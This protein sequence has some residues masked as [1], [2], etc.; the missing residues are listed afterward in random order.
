V[1]RTARWL[2][3]LLLAACG[4]DTARALDRANDVPTAR[5][6]LDWPFAPE[7]IWNQPIGAAAIY[8]A[9]G[10]SL[11]VTFVGADRSYLFIATPTDPQRDVFYPGPRPDAPCSTTAPVR[12][13]IRLSDDVVLS[14][15]ENAGFGNS[16]SI[17][18][19]DGHSLFELSGFARCARGGPVFGFPYPPD[20]LY[21][22]G[23]HGGQGGSGLSALG[24]TLRGSDLTGASP[25]RHALKLSL[26][27][28]FLYHDPADVDHPTA[29]F[30][31]PADRCDASALTSYKGTN[32]SLAMGALLAIPP[33][34]TLAQL[35]LRTAPG[36]KLFRAMQDYGAYVAGSAG[37]E[38]ALFGIDAAMMNAFATNYGYA[39]HASANDTGGQRDWFDDV[40]ALVRELQVVDN[41]GPSSVGGGGRP[42]A[43]LA[44]P[45][46][47]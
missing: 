14:M 10:T 38:G 12:A 40:R 25:I 8:A 7:S 28:R 36:A 43:P 24:G 27:P 1:T 19:P 3:A 20:D 13:T 44:P 4:W 37:S 35:G 32:P 29:C 17:V 31:W 34:V 30:R 16:V 2:A 33:T 15:G 23:L 18:Q 45:I 46:A 41:N 5:K 21:G 39:Y 11:E 9:P 42:R 47:D 26:P 6:K 22:L